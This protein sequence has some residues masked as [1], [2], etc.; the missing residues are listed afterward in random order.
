ML[1]REEALDRKDNSFEKREN[2]LNRKEQ[3]INKEQQRLLLQQKEANSL[4]EARQ[5]EIE[6]VAGLSSDQARDMI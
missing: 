3:K 6:R 5:S 1:Q 2:S 4:I